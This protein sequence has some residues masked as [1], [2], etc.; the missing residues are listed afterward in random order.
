MVG[1]GGGGY[2]LLL[3]SILKYTEAGVR[4]RRILGNAPPNLYAH[5]VYMSIF[6][7]SRGGGHGGFRYRGVDF[8]RFFL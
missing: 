8:A 3:Q 1:T 6:L 2:L 5:F 4:I 7:I